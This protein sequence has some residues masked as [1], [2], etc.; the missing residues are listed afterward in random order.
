M[1][2]SKLGS[3]S[4]GTSNQ[5]QCIATATAVPTF[6]PSLSFIITIA[7]V[8][9]VSSKPTISGMGYCSIIVTTHN[10]HVPFFLFLLACLNTP[11]YRNVSSFSYNQSSM[12]R[13]SIAKKSTFQKVGENFCIHSYCNTTS[14]LQS[15]QKY[16]MHHLFYQEQYS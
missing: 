10:Q 3:I 11:V 6:K 16:T 12:N 9:V 1:S 4:T 7:T 2:G 5:V 13:L 15:Q 14:N 8:Y